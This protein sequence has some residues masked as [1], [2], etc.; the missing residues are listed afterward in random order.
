MQEGEEAVERAR[1]FVL[2]VLRVSVLVG[3]LD[4]Y[5]SILRGRISCLKDV[6]AKIF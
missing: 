2:W 1:M 3:S 6:R 4:L 5:G